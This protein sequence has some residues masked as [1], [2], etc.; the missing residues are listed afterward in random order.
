MSDSRIPNVSTYT[1]VVRIKSKAG[2][3]GELNY[4]M[5][6]P[7]FINPNRAKKRENFVTVY[8][9]YMSAPGAHVP[10]CT[11]TAVEIS[12]FKCLEIFYP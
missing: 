5:E 2:K 9:A 8:K 12:C 1:I 6:G 4:K 7:L 3:V 10:G 11:I